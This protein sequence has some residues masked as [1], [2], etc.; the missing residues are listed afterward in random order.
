LWEGIFAVKVFW[1][2]LKYTLYL[3]PLAILVTVILR[4][5]T[6]NDPPE[7]QLI[8]DT[9]AI[10]SARRNLGGDFVMHTIRLRN[11]FALGD[12]FRVLDV[13]HLESAQD[14]QMTLRSKKNM[15]DEVRRFANAPESAASFYGFL[16]LYLRAMTSTIT[17][18]EE[19]G[20]TVREET[21]AQEVF[22]HSVSYR[23]EN[24]RYEYA[25]VN[26]EG[27]E[28][29]RTHTRLDLFIFSSYRDGGIDPDDLDNSG[30]LGRITIFDVN[31]PR[32]R[33]QI[34]R[35]QFESER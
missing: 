10:H 30:Y 20:V 35:F 18:T 6:T 27:V 29:D 14:L 5:A 2:I 3:V 4:V 34:D 24:D 13:V 19:G 8:L 9:P 12:V 28:I 11:P 17:E 33:A 21:L 32:Q 22:R 23:F 26:F 31:M 15:L 7:S 1:K 25:R 16:E